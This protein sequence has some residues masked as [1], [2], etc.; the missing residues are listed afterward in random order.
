MLDGKPQFKITWHDHHREPKCAPN[1][2]Y[3]D[4]VDLDCTAGRVPNCKTELPYPAQR[5]GYYLVRCRLC[6][7]SLVITTAGRLDDPRS[8]TMGCIMTNIRPA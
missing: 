7:M 6:S 8:V 2:E 1:P 3:P 5:C 4:G